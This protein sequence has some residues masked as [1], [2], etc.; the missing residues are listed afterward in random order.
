MKT[1]FLSCHLGDADRA[2]VR[3]VRSLVESHGL[4][5][6][7]GEV[8]GGR[9]LREAVMS[10]IQKAD[11]LIALMTKRANPPDFG[12]THPWVREEYVH[13]MALQKPAIA[14]FESG[15]VCAG[16]YK[17]NERIDF[18][19]KDPLKSF[20]KLS[21]TLGV[22]KKEW[23][24][25]Q[26]SSNSHEDKN[27]PV[28]RFAHVEEVI[29]HICT[30]YHTRLRNTQPLRIRIFGLHLGRSWYRLRIEMLQSVG[31]HTIDPDLRNLSIEMLIL[32]PKRKPFKSLNARW[33]RLAQE[34]IAEI[35]QFVTEF[36]DEL[37]SQRIQVRLKPLKSLP[38]R[39]AILIDS[40]ALYV[41]GTYFAK[42][43][44]KNN[45]G[46]HASKLHHRLLT[47]GHPEFED[48]FESVSSWFD[49][50]WQNAKSLL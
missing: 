18:N 36:K 24:Q 35:R 29:D 34:R 14:L 15:V 8:L 17:A 10:R 26:T 7:T 37:L 1:I 31:T 46:W 21:Q 12:G 25:F 43:T 9:A 49:Y 13:A 16:A 20:L 48:E 39:Y 19:P 41:S 23:E 27:F 28:V 6:I 32:D 4:Q 50:E 22:W 45:F 5:V 33:H 44:L 40:D 30:R 11:A 2:L 42:K 47:P 38:M 3:K